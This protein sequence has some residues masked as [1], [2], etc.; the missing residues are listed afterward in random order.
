MRHCRTAFTVH[1]SRNFFPNILT[2]HVKNLSPV[3]HAP[4]SEPLISQFSILNS[5]SFVLALKI[6]D[7]TAA[8]DTFNISLISL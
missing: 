1:I 6:S 8:G 4:G 7:S 2:F 5:L 3:A